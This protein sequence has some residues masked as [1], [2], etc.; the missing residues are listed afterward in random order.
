MEHRRIKRY[1]ERTNKVNPMFQVAKLEARE[2]HFQAVDDEYE[3]LTKDKTSPLPRPEEH[4][5]I[6]LGKR[7]SKTLKYLLKQNESDPA[8]KVC[9]CFITVP[10]EYTILIPYP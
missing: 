2:R 4:Y 8:Y 3:A 5:H 10:F 1:Y 7:D 6:G 9:F